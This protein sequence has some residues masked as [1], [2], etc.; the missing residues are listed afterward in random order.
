MGLSCVHDYTWLKT[1]R[2]LM[3]CPLWS[4]TKALLCARVSGEA[5]PL[6]CTVWPLQ[7]N[8]LPPLC[9]TIVPHSLKHLSLK[10]CQRQRNRRRESQPTRWGDGR[11]QPGDR[12]DMKSKPCRSWGGGG[13]KT[14]PLPL[15]NGTSR[16]LQETS[17]L[18]E[19]PEFQRPP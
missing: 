3:L 8:E 4:H 15:I 11:K 19:C 17:E 12:V 2:D 9:V 7:F 16:H 1:N 5:E 18:A 10:V 14:L 13:G 6:L